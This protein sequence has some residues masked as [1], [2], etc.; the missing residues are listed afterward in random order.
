[1]TDSTLTRLPLLAGGAVA[2]SLSRAGLWTFSRYMRAPLASTALLAMVTLT[3]LAGSNA[4]YFQTARHPA[5]L[6]APAPDVP[7]TASIV[8]VPDA[9]A[10]PQLRQAEVPQPVSQ[11]TTSSVAQPAPTVPDA[12]VGN[13]QVFELQKKLTELKLFEGTVDGFY[14][15]MTAR[16]IRAFEERNGMTP[17]GAISPGLVDAIL[18]ADTM[19]MAPQRVQVAEVAPQPMAAP[20]RTI[21]AAK[22]QLP[23]VGLAPVNAVQAPT[24]VE[25]AF[26]TVTSSAAETIDSIVAAVDGSRV[27]PTTPALRPTAALPLMAATA[28]PMPAPVQH[29]ASLEPVA[30]PAVIIPQ[31]EAIQQAAI[32]PAAAASPTSNAQLIEQ[33]QR[34]LASL[35]FLQGAIDGKP[36]EATAKAIRAFEIFHNYAPTGEVNPQLVGLLRDAGASI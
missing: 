36:G 29:V 6:F 27:T 17:T 35:G 23:P 11:E 1:M 5:P 15:P 10:L 20:V 33:V 28:Q 12:P 16:A 3:A 13:T 26:D 9:P 18:R 32:A 4:L 2:A 14:G 21:R 24:P 25:D 31:P 22:V 7:E 34:G 19:G 30:P 8:E